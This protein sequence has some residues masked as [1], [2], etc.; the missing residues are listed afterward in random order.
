MKNKNLPAYWK[1]LQIIIFSAM[2][3]F[4]AWN[5]FYTTSQVRGWVSPKLTLLLLGYESVFLFIFLLGGV[6]FFFPSLMSAIVK[7]SIK[8][9]QKLQ[10]ASWILSIFFLMLPIY[11]LI[12]TTFFNLLTLELKPVTFPY[13]R[14]FIYLLSI[15]V[16]AFFL[17]KDRDTIISFPK[18]VLSFLIS[19]TMLTLALS[20]QEVVAYPFPL[21]WS[22]GNRIWD[23]SVLFGRARYD[24]PANQEIHAFIDGGRQALWGIPFLLPNVSL[25]GIRFWDALVSTLPYALLGWMLFK[26]SAK[27]TKLWLLLGLWSF[28]FLSQGPIYTPLVLSAILVTGTQKRTLWIA[29]PLVA[30]AG[31]YAQFTRWTW[32]FAPA[33]W[34]GMWT[35]GRGKL[36]AK[37]I[38]STVWWRA[39]TLVCAGLLGGYLVPLLK[40]AGKSSVS[41]ENV[42]DS[43][44]FQPLIWDRLLPNTTFPPG[45]ILATLMATAP[46]ALLFGYLIAS[47]R[48]DLNIWQWLAIGGGLFAFL[49]VGLVISTKIGGGSNLHNLDMF[50]IGLLFTASVAW[51]KSGTAWLKKLNFASWPGFVLLAA[52]AIPSSLPLL[53]ASPLGLPDKETTQAALER[54]QEEVSQ[55]AEQGEVLFL[56]HRQLLTFG[57]VEK[58]PLVDDYEKKY[59]MHHA[60]S[61]DKAYFAN[62]YK[63]L[64]EHRFSLIVSEPLN[65]YYYSDEHNF[66]AENNDWVYWV[67]EPILCYYEKLATFKENRVEL[68][69]PREGE[70]SYCPPR[71]P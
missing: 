68:L 49:V 53:E 33:M 54:V 22:E 27:E 48:W 59:L 60:H 15:L 63:E 25:K 18:L 34:A 12:C 45:I 13:L 42:S 66:A 56:D 9:R 38:S 5:A 29:V 10:W 43:I 19:G 57:Y 3:L 30:V 65:A 64:A 37:K 36:N 67:S 23:Y 51:E 52:V 71:L 46:V 47:K 21:H 28:L 8:V 6:Y 32:Q 2:M 7:T 31:Y 24:F 41:I 17:T 61:S 11:L 20:F 70:G 39:I 14:I 16:G 69:V 62:F 58:I 1:V 50:L 4:L 26:E 40:N 35:L 44:T 55:A